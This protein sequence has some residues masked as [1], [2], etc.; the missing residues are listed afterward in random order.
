M[1]STTRGT[2]GILTANPLLQQGGNLANQG[3]APSDNPQ[4]LQ[5]QV[6]SPTSSPSIAALEG[7]TGYQGFGQSPYAFIYGPYGY[8]SYGW[9]AGDADK[10]MAN[11][12]PQRNFATVGRAQ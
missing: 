5:Q 4:T 2:T 9:G 11:P 7:Y 1:P 10:G 3:V 6:Y 8:G 12:G